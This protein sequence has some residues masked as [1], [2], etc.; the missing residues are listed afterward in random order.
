[1]KLMTQMFLM[2]EEGALMQADETDDT[3][4]FLMNEEG[5]K[6]KQVTTG[7]VDF[8]QPIFSPDGRQILFTRQEGQKKQLYFTALDGSF[9]RPLFSTPEEGNSNADWTDQLDLENLH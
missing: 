5:S 9:Q 4:V 8:F 3:D 7:K 1:M 2:K 6:L